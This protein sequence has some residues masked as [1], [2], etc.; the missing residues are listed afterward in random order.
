MDKEKARRLIAESQV[1][2]LYE[3]L[4]SQRSATTQDVAA[5]TTMNLEAQHAL[6]AKAN[7][8]ENAENAFKELSAQQALEGE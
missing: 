2:A 3:S 7:Q 1:E 6:S 5:L 4:G 8:I